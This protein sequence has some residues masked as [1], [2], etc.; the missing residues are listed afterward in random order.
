MLEFLLGF[1]VT[2]VVIDGGATGGS[3]HGR[4]RKM[5]TSLKH[6]RSSP[7]TARQS[8]TMA[9]WPVLSVALGAPK[10]H[11]GPIT[12]GNPAVPWGFL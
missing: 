2:P 12:L 7:L 10:P 4:S 3:R 11:V 6:S 5:T 8:A 1:T 9:G